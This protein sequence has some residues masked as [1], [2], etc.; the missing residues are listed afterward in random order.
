MGCQ[1]RL[2]MVGLALGFELLV[3]EVGALLG[4][5]AVHLLGAGGEDGHEGGVG[6]E[7]VE[8]GPGFGGSASP[9]GVDEADGDVLFLLEVRGRRSR[10]RRRSSLRSRGCRCDQPVAALTSS[11]G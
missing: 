11:R 5:L 3:G 7:G 1:S 8:A 6:T 10:L 2:G 9:G 4:G